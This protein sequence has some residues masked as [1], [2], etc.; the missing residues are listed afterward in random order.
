[1][2]MLKNGYYIT[3]S[4]EDK[5]IEQYES[6]ANGVAEIIKYDGL[7]YLSNDKI[8]KSDSPNEALKKGMDLLDLIRGLWTLY[9]GC[10]LNVRA[11][12]IVTINDKDDKSLINKDI[13]F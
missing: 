1:M 10:C 11:N 2:F 9:G 7:W 8:R 3:L 4:G 13:D 12:G 5:D 6:V